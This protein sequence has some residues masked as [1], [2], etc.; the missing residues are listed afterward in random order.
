MNDWKYRYFLQK[1][2]KSK[3]KLLIIKCN[4][5]KVPKM[6]TSSLYFF[7]SYC[8]RIWIS[9]PYQWEQIFS[10]FPNVSLMNGRFGWILSLV[11]LCFGLSLIKGTT[12]KNRNNSRCKFGVT[13]VADVRFSTSHC[14][15][16]WIFKTETYLCFIIQQRY[17]KGSQGNNE[18]ELICLSCFCISVMFTCLT[19]V[20][21]EYT[22]SLF[23]I[24][25]RVWSQRLPGLKE[26]HRTVWTCSKSART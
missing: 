4:E 18:R 13:L 9:V 23:H 25:H 11:N 1:V 14:W 21:K 24:V 15:A 12:P 20:L 7:L 26:L 17:E 3:S 10:I 8:C 5:V 2:D 6:C 16:T 22:V 19:P